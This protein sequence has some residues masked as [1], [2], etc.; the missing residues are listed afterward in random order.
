MLP[1][2]F[3]LRTWEM[4][5]FQQR[6]LDKNITTTLPNDVFRNRGLG[7]RPFRLWERTHFLSTKSCNGNT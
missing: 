2:L 7:R 4:V 6:M 3:L 5:C 1:F